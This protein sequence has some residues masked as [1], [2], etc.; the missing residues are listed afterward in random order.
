MGLGVTFD[1]LGFRKQVQNQT[2]NNCAV[3]EDE[4]L[5]SGSIFWQTRSRLQK[6]SST[7]LFYV[8]FTDQ[9]YM[10]QTNGTYI[11]KP[12]YPEGRKKIYIGLRLNTLRSLMDLLEHKSYIIYC[13]LCVSYY[14][15]LWWYTVKP[16]VFALFGGLYWIRFQILFD[17]KL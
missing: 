8:H 2:K 14:P 9:I 13:W 4:D 3:F 15:W 5:L 7:R 6:V 1:L 11:L 17:L 16:Q 10:C 12:P